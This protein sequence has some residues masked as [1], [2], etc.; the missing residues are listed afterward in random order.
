MEGEVQTAMASD[1]VHR[2]RQAMGMFEQAH[3]LWIRR[4]PMARLARGLDEAPMLQRR[5]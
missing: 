2:H 1:Q 4:Q 3:M 5:T